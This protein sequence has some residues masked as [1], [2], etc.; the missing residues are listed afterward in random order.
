MTTLPD[1]L[2][3]LMIC[4][5]PVAMLIDTMRNA[6]IYNTASNLPLVGIWFLISV[7]LCGVGVHIVYKNENGYVKIV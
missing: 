6:L 3:S 1:P 4:L 2:N 7:I 5:N